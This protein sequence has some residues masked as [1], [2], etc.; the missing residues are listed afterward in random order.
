[1]VTLD[2]IRKPVADDLAA[3]DEMVCRHFAD[4]DSPMS[5]MLRYALSSRGKGVRPLIAL[6]SAAINSPTGRA[7][8]RASLAAMLVEM[9][10][11]ASL[12]HDDVI[13]E[14]DMRRGRQSLNARWQ[15]KNAVIAGDYILARTMSIGMSSAQYDLVQ[16][17]FG[18]IATLCEGEVLQGAHTRRRDTSR[19]DYLE[20]IYKKTAALISVS[21]SAGAM[22]SGASR[23]KVDTMR[24]YGEALGMAFQ[25]QDDI[26]DYTSTDSATGKPSH[27]DLREGKLTLP[28]IALL[29]EAGETRRTELLALLDRCAAD[30]QAVG[31]LSRA[32]VE[33]GG[34]EAAARTMHSYLNRA[35][36]LAADYEP[37]PLR[38]A[39]VNLCAYVGQRDR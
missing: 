39:L 36:A 15:S 17:I 25:I 8:K 23:E 29:E 4:D 2:T 12:I 7:G 38:D 13:D 28:L 24:R 37:S 6:L 5:E 19:K 21:A 1:M 33:G 26:L 27:N 30:E 34:T 9:I 10:H 16:H 35:A 31:E 32:V 22:A 18:T 3:F 14:A 11:V 20:I